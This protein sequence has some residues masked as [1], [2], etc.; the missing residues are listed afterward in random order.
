MVKKKPSMLQKLALL[1]GW[2]VSC[3]GDSGGSLTI[4]EIGQ[5]LVEKGLASDVDTAMKQIQKACKMTD[6]QVSSAVFDL[7]SFNRIFFISIVADSFKDA[8][9]DI[10]N[11][12]NSEHLGLNLKINNY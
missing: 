12:Q 11:H 2:F 10:E 6:R 3:S 9:N 5:L 4:K 7:N 8:I 1:K